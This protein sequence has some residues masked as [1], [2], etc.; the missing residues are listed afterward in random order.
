MPVT[1]PIWCNDFMLPTQLQCDHVH[2]HTGVLTYFQTPN[3]Y[4]SRT[5][6]DLKSRQGKPRDTRHVEQK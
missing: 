6:E 2:R 1:V 5:Q 4:F 3:F